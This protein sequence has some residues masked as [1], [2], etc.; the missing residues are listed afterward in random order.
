MNAS[1][2]T[3]DRYFTNIKAATRL[4]PDY[5]SLDYSLQLQL[6]ISQAVNAGMAALPANLNAASPSAAATAPRP[7]ATHLDEVMRGESD[8]AILDSAAGALRKQPARDA[9]QARENHTTAS[10]R[11][12]LCIPCRA[13][14]R[15][16]AA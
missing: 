16:P 2:A 3:L 11:S 14:L 8:V 5:V 4:S 15:Y 12:M 7:V 10:V 1:D 6:G 9:S 13:G